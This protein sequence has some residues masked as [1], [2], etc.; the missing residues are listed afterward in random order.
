MSDNEPEKGKKKFKMP[1]TYVIL[2]GVICFIAVLSWFVP[3][4]AYE[5]NANGDAISGTYH[6]VE[7][8]PQGLWDVFMAPITGM[9]G[10]G[11][12]S[13]AIAISLTILLIGSFLEMM[14]E[15]GSKVIPMRS[16]L[17]EKCFSTLPSADKLIIIQKGEMG[18]I[19]SEM[20][21]AGKTAREAADIANDTM[22]VTK[23]Q[24]AAMLA[25]SLFGW[26]TPAADPKNY[27]DNGNPIKPAKKK[28]REYER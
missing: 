18:Y 4:G 14:E 22:G 20:Q 27:D 8:N 26:Q 9:L 11:A 23:K 5:L 19:P 28:N 2:F 10:S 15:T 1:N 16:S 21:I 12:I 13:G 25:G 7:S 17:P 24:E 3:G 6:I